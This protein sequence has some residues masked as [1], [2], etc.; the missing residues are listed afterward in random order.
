MLS[1]GSFKNQDKALRVVRALERKGLRVMFDHEAML[2]N[3]GTGM[4]NAPKCIESAAAVV[5]CFSENYEKRKNCMREL[6]HADNYDKHLFCEFLLLTVSR[7]LS[8]THSLSHFFPSY[9]AQMLTA[10][11]QGAS[12]LERACWH[13]L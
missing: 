13:S 6:I 5:V 12:P 1:D 7:H 4:G 10:W 2:F 3:K 11:S 9:P 8:P